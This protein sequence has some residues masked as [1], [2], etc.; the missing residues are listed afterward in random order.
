MEAIAAAAAALKESKAQL[1]SLKV[2]HLG[3]EISPDAY[4]ALVAQYEA[5]K[6][7]DLTGEA[8]SKVTAAGLVE[9]PALFPEI[10][11]IFCSLPGFPQEVKAQLPSLKV[12]HLGAEISPDAY[13]ALVAQYEANKR[14]DLTGE[15]CSKVTA[16]GLAELP[17]LFPEVEAIFSLLPSFPQEIKS[18]LPSF[19]LAHLGAEISPD[20]YEALV[21]QYKANSKRLDMTGEAYSK[22][23]KAGLAEV[24][25]L[26]PET[27]VLLLRAYQSYDG[28]LPIA[29][30]SDDDLVTVRDG[31]SKIKFI[32]K[33]V[34]LSAFNNLEESYASDNRLVLESADFDCISERPLVHELL[35]FF[36][37]TRQL[38]LRPAI[39]QSRR[40][41][42]L[43][44]HELIELREARED[45]QVAVLGSQIHAKVFGRLETDV[46][47]GPAGALMT[48]LRQCDS[49][50]KEQISAI[51]QDAWIPIDMGSAALDAQHEFSLLTDQGLL[52]AAACFPEMTALFIEHRLTLNRAPAGT[53]APVTLAGLRRLKALCPNLTIAALGSQVPQEVYSEWRRQYHAQSGR[54]SIGDARCDTLLCEEE[55]LLASL[56]SGHDEAKQVVAA[57][58][59]AAIDE[60]STAF[61]EIQSLLVAGKPSASAVSRKRV[62][63][64]ALASK[65]KVESDVA[66]SE[67]RQL[68]GLAALVRSKNLDSSKQE[69]CYQV[70]LLSAQK[71]L[72]EAKSATAEGHMDA[73]LA[74]VTQGLQALIE[75]DSLDPST[76][77]LRSQLEKARDNCS[78]ISA[79]N[80]AT[81]NLAPQL[82]RVGG[83][84]AAE[85]RLHQIETELLMYFRGSQNCPVASL[86]YYEVGSAPDA[87]AF[88]HLNA[89]SEWIEWKESE[90]FSEIGISDELVAESVLDGL[91]RQLFLHRRRKE[92][93]A[94][95]INVAQRLRVVEVSPLRAAISMRDEQLLS[96]LISW[97]TNRAGDAHLDILTSMPAL[98]DDLA[99]MIAEGYSEYH[100]RDISTATGTLN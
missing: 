44:A 57:F 55:E 27:E 10:E 12:A 88:G 18:Q 69:V 63:S 8:C 52:E 87:P 16:A 1:P 94:R 21:E 24:A 14:L 2:A 96:D 45:L 25:T 81:K 15:A 59:T 90:K 26:F 73:A 64:C 50:D 11:A 76:A 30:I 84:G 75:A 5:N 95:T 83:T 82:G 35:Q 89:N 99:M 28:Q 71:A 66:L 22:V 29:L 79:V 9:L 31:F 51:K 74:M 20:A 92:N 42:T 39:A 53:A 56:D 54:L 6:R 19:T 49:N 80:L 43:T 60:M 37:R 23:T 48:K 17:A 98:C 4:E 93:D 78:I 7:L 3:A 100:L 68:A 65:A 32:A 33:G 77:S 70:A 40:T 61:P 86:E 41:S 85:S 38:F 46:Y 34:S 97:I 72:V 13:E 62:L 36:N 91:K 67:G 47:A 58:H